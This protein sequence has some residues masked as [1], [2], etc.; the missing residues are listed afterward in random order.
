MTE[1]GSSSKW[2]LIAMAAGC[3]IV[4]LIMYRMGLMA[5]DMPDTPREINRLMNER[6]I[7]C[8][9][10]VDTERCKKA[11]EALKEFERKNRLSR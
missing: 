11:V 2:L 7:A 3:A 4:A 10:R 6:S 8:Q 5:R 9:D 1:P